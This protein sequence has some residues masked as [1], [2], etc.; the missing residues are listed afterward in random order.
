MNLLLFRILVVVCCF[1]HGTRTLVSVDLLKL[2]GSLKQ[3]QLTQIDVMLTELTTGTL[4]KGDIKAV[5]SLYLNSPVDEPVTLLLESR[6]RKVAQPIPRSVTFTKENSTE[7]KKIYVHAKGVGDAEINIQYNHTHAHQLDFHGNKIHVLVVHS[8]PLKYVSIVIGW[9]Y[10]FA[11]AISNYPQV[12]INFKRKSVVGLNFDYL[13][14]NLTGF[15][16]YSIFNISLYSVHVVQEQYFKEFGG[17]VIPVQ[18]NDVFFGFHNT[19]ITAVC[20]F[21]CY[22]Y[23]RGTQKLS[24]LC[25]ILVPIMWLFAS[26]SLI[27]A[28]MHKISWLM[29]LNFFSYIKLVVT[30]IKYIPQV[31]MNYARKSTVGWSIAFVYLDLLGGGFSLLQ[32]FMIAH[33]NDEWSSIFGDFTKLGLGMLT[34][35]FDGVFLIQHYVLYREATMKLFPPDT[36]K[37][38]HEMRIEGI[39]GKTDIDLSGVVLG[40]DKVFTSLQKTE[41]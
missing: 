1:V 27:P 35:I 36:P 15:T 32:M 12:Y 13:S 34:L 31:Y 7:P 19:F 23:D 40:T 11:W 28:L 10:F 39:E 9:V 37:A 8:I 41:I 22:L 25:N 18:L 20:I 2:K 16:A 30:I 4:E 21:Q 29:Y 26:A 33:N 38:W 3:H 17:S 5:F 14:Y 24:L 6:N